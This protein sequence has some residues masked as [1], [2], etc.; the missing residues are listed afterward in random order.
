MVNGVANSRAAMNASG[1]YELQLPA[2]RS[3]TNKNGVQNI[4]LRTLQTIIKMRGVL[5]SRVQ[6]AD[7]KDSETSG[8]KGGEKAVRVL[9]SFVS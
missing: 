8:D 2:M 6:R 3:L 5:H 4:F 9:L 1:C 7:A